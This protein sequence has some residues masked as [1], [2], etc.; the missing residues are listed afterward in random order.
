MQ[1][2]TLDLARESR[3]VLSVE[4][5][6]IILGVSPGHAYKSARDGSIPTVRIGKK[7]VVPVQR[8]K[9]LLGIVD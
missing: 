5:A 3:A 2:E 1:N 9:A 8:L 6:G 7:Y 4:E